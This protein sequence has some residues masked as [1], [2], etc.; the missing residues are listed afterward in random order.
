ML[1]ATHFIC[2]IVMSFTK[3]DAWRYSAGLIHPI[4]LLPA[5]IRAALTLENRPANA[6]LDAEVPATKEYFPATIIIYLD[7]AKV[8][9]GVPRPT[10]YPAMGVWPSA[11]ADIK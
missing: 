7:P 2:P 8:K 4:E 9:S 5:A 6:G 1:A 10:A 11:A 3:D